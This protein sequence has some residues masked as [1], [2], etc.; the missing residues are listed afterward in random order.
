MSFM[1]FLGLENPDYGNYAKGILYTIYEI[2]WKIVY[3][4]NS[5]IDVITGLFYKL[6]GSNYLGSGSESLVEEQDLLSKLFNQNIVSDISLIMTVTSVALMMVFGGIAIIKQNYFG[7]EEAKSM[8]GVIKNMVLATIFLICLTPLALFAIS[9]I[10][11]LTS[12]LVSVFGDNSNTSLADLL[13][14]SSFGGDPIAAYNTINGTEITSWMQMENG[15]LFELAYGEIETGVT[16]YWFVYLLGGILVLYNL[17]VI[18]IQLIKRI[19]NIIILYLVAPLYVARMVDDGGNKFREW[20]NKA[21]SQ[22]ISIV[23]T[24]VAFMILISLTGM[25]SQLELIQLS[26][27]SGD[28]NVVSSVKA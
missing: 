5:L 1:N 6:A 26:D 18:A 21:L 7:K 27:V 14:Y 4:I 11:T 15:F 24:V 9:S 28:G 17:V 20:K 8:T 2:F 12:S 10:S 22:L 16:F 23:G 25:I 19:F 13:F 3:A